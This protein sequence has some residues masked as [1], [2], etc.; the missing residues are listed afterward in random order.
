M[1][2]LFVFP[3]PESVDDTREGLVILCC[4]SLPVH[5]I[6][7]SCCN[8]SISIGKGKLIKL[9]KKKTSAEIVVNMRR[10]YKIAV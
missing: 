2:F 10:E 8:A 7:F 4:R 3:C 6:S 1:I 9:Q 5:V